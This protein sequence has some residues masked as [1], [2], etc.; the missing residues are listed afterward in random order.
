LPYIIPFHKENLN[1][2]PIIFKLVKSAGIPEK[3]YAGTLY[4]SNAYRE[5]FYTSWQWIRLV[6]NWV[7]PLFW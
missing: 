7:S 4:F 1:R 5:A 3:D 6:E 2:G